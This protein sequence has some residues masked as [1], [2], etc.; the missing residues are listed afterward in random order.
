MTCV[1]DVLRPR[2]IVLCLAVLALTTATDAQ[3][4]SPELKNLQDAS[5]DFY[6]AGDYTAALQFA[7]RAL[8]LVIREFGAEHEQTGIQYFSLGLI[9][10]AA[11]NH[12]AAEKYFAETVRLREK[13]YGS[14][15]PSVADALD[16]LGAV[17]LRSKRVDAAEP[18]FR[19][20][21][22]IRQDLVGR[23]HAFSAGGHAN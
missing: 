19:R 17:Y 14:G 5:H 20:A 12:S 22:K 13:V 9:A 4:P 11:G 21:L 23:D 18:L 6:R 7:E 15:S 1:F 16:R 2:L 10:Q 3:Q 8:P